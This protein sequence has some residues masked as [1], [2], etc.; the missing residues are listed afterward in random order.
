MTGLVFSLTNAD[1]A[2]TTL[3]RVAIGFEEASR[4]YQ[5]IAGSQAVLFQA[6]NQSYKTPFSQC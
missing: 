3:K 5:S 1:F 4:P 6:I 2:A